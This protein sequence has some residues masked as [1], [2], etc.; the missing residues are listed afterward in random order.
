MI[1]SEFLII[2]CILVAVGIALMVIGYNKSQPTVSDNIIGFLED[3]S[4]EKAPDDIKSSK[5]NVY[6]FIGFGIL[7]FLAGMGFI[8]KSRSSVSSKPAA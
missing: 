1:R 2:G 8:Y 7:S 6:L 4:G 5:T 3:L